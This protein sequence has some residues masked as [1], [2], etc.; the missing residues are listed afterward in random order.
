MDEDLKQA[1]ELLARHFDIPAE[2]ALELLIIL[3]RAESQ[4]PHSVLNVEG[5][6][7]AVSIEVPRKNGCIWVLLEKVYRYTFL[8]AI[9]E[10]P[11]RYRAIVGVKVITHPSSTPR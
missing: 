7:D 6:P 3:D 1:L 8:V 9:R 10:T 11:R 4:S 2:A 5:R